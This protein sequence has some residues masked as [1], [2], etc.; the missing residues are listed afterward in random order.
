MDTKQASKWEQIPFNGLGGGNSLL[1][2]EGFEISYNPNPGS[3]ISF[4]ASDDGGEETAICIPRGD[5][6]RK[7]LILNGDFR[8]D[9]ERL[10][11]DGLKA[12]IEF[13]RASKKT[14]EAPGLPVIG[15]RKAA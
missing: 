15:M 4:F 8:D 6:T 5:G 2:C 9:Y 12:C 7:Y 11:A 1:R 14:T 10:S 3:M 13:F